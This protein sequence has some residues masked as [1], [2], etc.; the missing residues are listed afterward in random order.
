MDT[1]SEHRQSIVE[2]FQNANVIVNG[3]SKMKRVT[4]ALQW[5]QSF[6]NKEVCNGIVVGSEELNIIQIPNPEEAGIGTGGQVWP[7]A[8]VLTKYLE[9]RFGTPDKQTSDSLTDKNVCELGSGTGIVSIGCSMLGAKS[10]TVTDQVDCFPLI[11]INC[12]RYFKAGSGH[13]SEP[14]VS[15]RDDSIWY[16]YCRRFSSATDGKSQDVVL[17]GDMYIKTYE[18]GESIDYLRP[19]AT[20]GATSAAAAADTQT[21]YAPFDLV[22]VSDC[23]LPKLYPVEPLVESLQNLLAGITRQ[24]KK[25]FALISYEHRPFP[26]YDPRDEFKHLATIHGLRVSI[27]PLAEHHEEYC[28]DDIEIW[29]VTRVDADDGVSSSQFDTSGEILEVVT[30]G[31]SRMEV[32]VQIRSARAEKT[33]KIFQEPSTVVGCYVWPSAVAVSRFLLSPEGKALISSSKAA[34]VTGSRVVAVE[35]GA[36]CGLCTLVMHYLGM[37]VVATD[38]ADVVRL[39]QRNFMTHIESLIDRS[40]APVSLAVNGTDVPLPGMLDQI[41]FDRRRVILHEFDWQKAEQE[42]GEASGVGALQAA[43]KVCRGKSSANPYPELLVCS[44]LLYATSAIAP[45]SAAISR[46]AGPNTTILLCNEMRTALDVFLSNYSSPLNPIYE[47]CQVST[48]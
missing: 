17:A 48:L 22:L 31:D 43:I 3:S 21:E 41:D 10:V 27:I 1:P 20:S 4:R 2:V 28:C 24:G 42:D 12:L 34:L 13:I 33:F 16:R 6:Q 29:E 47:V 5:R 37:H 32:E 9:R 11:E 19:N 23:I 8:V 39:L 36:G 38:T 35:L 14:P 15:V 26:D 44:D 30:F 40:A 46:I 18:W 25:P 7:A 45:L